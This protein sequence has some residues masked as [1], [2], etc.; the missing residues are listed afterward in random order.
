V[1]LLLPHVRP[2][3]LPP[4][5]YS[6]FSAPHSFMLMA[7]ILS[8]LSL[9]AVVAAQSGFSK[10]PTS[11]P[12]LSFHVNDL[13]LIITTDIIILS[14]FIFFALLQ[15]PRFV[16]RFS[17]KSEW[18][19][20]HILRT[21]PLT[22][23]GNRW[24]RNFSAASIPDILYNATMETASEDS[25][26][27]QSHNSR[28]HRETKSRYPRRQSRSCAGYLDHIP[29]ILNRSAMPG[30]T[31]GRLL[32]VLGY[33]LI[34]LIASL[35]KSSPFADYLRT[36]Y[37]AVGQ[38]PIVFALATKNNILGMLLAL[39]YEK[40]CFPIFVSLLRS[41]LNCLCQINYLHRTVGLLIAITSN[42]HA[43]GYCK[44]VNRFLSAGDSSVP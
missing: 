36:G 26:T 2:P 35:Y 13:N 1:V 42:I 24:K 11:N 41:V 19:L 4:P 28:K 22:G 27:W 3:P 15:L 34:V 17:R 9:S 38:L 14:F 7:S 5:S 30:Y 12:I 43:I 6:Q 32:V 16:I 25:H 40:V 23:A 39:G 8:V 10:P 31:V 29:A 18:F 44:S 33:C 21:V 37:V 20:G